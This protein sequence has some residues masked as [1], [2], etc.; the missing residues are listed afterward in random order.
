MQQFSNK[1]WYY[2]FRQPSGAIFGEAD[3]EVYT[4]Q[5]PCVRPGEPTIKQWT[6]TQWYQC[7]VKHSL[8]SPV[9]DDIQNWLIV[10]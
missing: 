1:Q 6:T 8:L 7:Q 2:K 9:L 4:Y 3:I 5:L 10:A